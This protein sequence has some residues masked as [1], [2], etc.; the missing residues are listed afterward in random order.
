MADWFG[1]VF[2]VILIPVIMI[3]CGKHYTNKA[4][5]T[6]NHFVGYRT[7]R[8]MKNNETWKFAHNYVGKL[9]F[10]MGLILLPVSVLPMIFVRGRIEEIGT[11]G[12]IISTIQI[13]P[14]LISMLLTEKALK[15]NFDKE[16]NRKNGK[17]E[18]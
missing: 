2:V 7:E 14:F 9:L 6:I 4:P 3:I 10:K 1:M 12:A 15:D 8:S 5:K 18:K 11:L 13:F 17:S 16:G